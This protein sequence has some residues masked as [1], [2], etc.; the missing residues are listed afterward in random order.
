MMGFMTNWKK[1][2]IKFGVK[3]LTL[4]YLCFDT[5]K[6]KNEGKYRVFNE[7]KNT[8]FECVSGR[9]PF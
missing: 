8:Y 3:E 4:Y 9:E 1:C 2:V 6:N 7:S 5:K